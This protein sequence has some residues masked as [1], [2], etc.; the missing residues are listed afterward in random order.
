MR[1]SDALDIPAF[2]DLSEFIARI[3]DSDERVMQSLR[4]FVV[5]KNLETK[6]DQLLRAVGH[7][8]DQKRDIGRYIYGTFGSGKSH[9]MTVLAK[10]LEHDETVYDVGD[11]ALHRLR[12]QHPWIDRHSPLVV[13]VN[14]MGKQTLVSALFEAYAEALPPDAPPIAFTD[15]DEV[16]ALIDK[17]AERLGGMDAL[18]GR[19]VEDKAIPSLGF[20]ER[21]RQGTPSQRLDLAARLDTWRNHGRPVRP[22]DLWVDAD[23]GF[24]R[25]A[26]HAKDA[27]YTAIVWLIDELVIW[28]RGKSADQYVQ[29]INDLSALVDHDQTS[30]RPTPFFVAVAV[31]QDVAETCPQDLSE[32]GFREQLGFIGNRFQPRL[33]LEDQDLFEVTSRR[34]LK[35]KQEHAEAWRQA[36]AQ[37]FQKH[38]AEIRKLSGEIEPAQVQALYPFHPAL[39][40]VLVDVTQ[41]LSRNRS[42]MSA[43]YGLLHAERDLEVGHFIPVGSLFDVVFTR[44]SVEDA[45]QRTQSV[46]AQRLAEAAES[47]ERLEHKLDQASEEVSADPV[48]L[49]QLVKTVL[50]CQLSDRDY[51]RTEPLSK[52]VKASFLLHLNQRDIQASHP[53]LGLSKVVKL[54]RQIDST[55]V[56]LGE[57]TDP[58]I[59]ILTDRVDS[60]A[61]LKAA[62]A[63]MHH[64]A[65]FAYI[66]RVID[67]VL[68]LG[69][70]SGKEIALDVPGWRGTKR[71]GRLLLENVRTLSYAGKQNQFE[72]GESE[73]LILVDY[74]FDEDPTKTR[75]DDIQTLQRARS[76]RRQWTVAW[77]PAH[78]QRSELSALDQAAAVDIIRQDKARFL[79][80]Y[81]TRDADKISRALELHQAKQRQLLED[82]V[83]RVYI[84]EGEVHACS[85]LL[86]SVTHAGKDIGKVPQG[87][88]KD[89]LDVRYPNHP[90][91]SRRVVARDLQTLVDL[92][93]R[94]AAT[95]TADNLK[96]SD[97]DLVQAFAVPLEMVYP[98]QNSISR[99]A[100]GRYLTRVH[101]LLRDGERTQARALRDVLSADVQSGDGFGFT[102]E[103]VQFFLFYLLHAEGYEALK[104]G[105][106]TVR[107]FRDLPSDFELKKADMVEHAEWDAAL[108]VDAA[109][110]GGSKRADIPS[111]PEQ[112]KLSR[113]VEA[114][115]R[116][117]RSR[118]T[119]LKSA[120]GEVLAWT[121]LKL[122]DSERARTLVALESTL[123]ALGEQQGNAERVRRL[124]EL[125]KA[126]DTLSAFASVIRSVEA[127]RAALDSLSSQQAAFTIVAERGDDAERAAVVLA[128]KNRLRAP[129][130][131]PLADFAPGWQAE[132]QSCLQA[133]VGRTPSPPP[134]VAEA[135]PEVAAQDAE[136]GGGRVLTRRASGVSR[137]ALAKELARLS[138]DAVRELGPDGDDAHFD[139]EISLVRRR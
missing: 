17:D 89:I 135:G 80:R 78:F 46:L 32:K 93:V 85:E 132:A 139:I 79:E 59:K 99:R 22:E 102:D 133:I 8:L 4:T 125:D 70:G 37:T 3:N 100:D 26:R 68:G 94:A 48:E 19:L 56:T 119:E 88:A 122:E 113:E 104:N 81:N 72:A 69:L 101:G 138:K 2:S 47:Y 24:A 108:R 98:G 51:F 105:S 95:G 43:L 128:L 10:M 97:M 58:S 16:F 18:L 136:R 76:H 87:L 20:Y 83:R 38:Q 86:D 71:R 96:S 114:Q 118:L 11:E 107:V 9:L 130:S 55:E 82:A 52:R 90:Q 115:A 124:A 73:F 126:S 42:A 116:E 27:G 49:R 53:R 111:V 34:V 106:L 25:I 110:F 45:R 123:V 65:R 44:D 74:P 14:M 137:A 127:E 54:F 15:E 31:Q 12:A 131:A 60:D 28:I 13:R 121:G 66:R 41:G 39:M 57:G 129:V 5:P 23:E 109:L 33:D 21:M 120:L 117:L 36:V 64:S 35:P 112:A 61:V 30:A 91:F 63:E 62:L 29:Q 50:L 1:I 103:V 7:N 77:L 92:V 40:R 67:Q 6:L 75:Q 134:S 84:D